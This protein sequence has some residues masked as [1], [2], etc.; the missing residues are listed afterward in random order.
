MRPY[1]TGTPRVW[2]LNSRETREFGRDGEQE[3]CRFDRHMRFLTEYYLILRIR[4]IL[5][6]ATA[7]ERDIVLANLSV[8]PSVRHSLV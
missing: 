5:Q 1:S 4:I 3:P 6:V 8:R 7:G 2:G